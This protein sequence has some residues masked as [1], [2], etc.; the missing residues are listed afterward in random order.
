MWV[1]ESLRAARDMERSI[2]RAGGMS[3]ATM[4]RREALG[5]EPLQPPGP[6]LADAMLWGVGRWGQKRWGYERYCRRPTHW[7]GRWGTG[8]WSYAFWGRARTR[9]G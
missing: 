7:A 1:R 8:R 2:G 9:V 3:M 6:A 4:A 5:A